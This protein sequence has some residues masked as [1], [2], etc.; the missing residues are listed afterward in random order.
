M[1]GSA[2]LGFLV[3]LLLILAATCSTNIL[4]ISLVVVRLQFFANWMDI[5]LVWLELQVLNLLSMGRALN[6]SLFCFYESAS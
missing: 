3:I 4:V 6:R 1:N 5:V 2:S